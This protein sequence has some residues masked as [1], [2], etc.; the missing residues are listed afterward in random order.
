MGCALYGH[1]SGPVFA[2]CSSCRIN[3]NTK[4][5]IKTELGVLSNSWKMSNHLELYLTSHFYKMRTVKF[6][7]W[8]FLNFRWNLINTLLSSALKIKY[9]DLW[10]VFSFHHP[11]TQ[12]ASLF[13]TAHFHLSSTYF[14][15]LSF[16]NVLYLPESLTALKKKS[17]SFKTNKTT[18]MDRTKFST[19]KVVQA[20][21][22]GRNLEYLEEVR[23]IQTPH[24]RI[25]M[26]SVPLH[27]H[28]PVSNPKQRKHWDQIKPPSIFGE[29]IK[30]TSWTLIC[31]L[32]KLILYL[33][34]S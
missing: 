3:Y 30:S 10:G 7:G 2:A 29:V 27:R 22:C 21:D 18:N 14:F 1:V 28:T 20:L 12:T 32:I 34:L 6:C 25:E 5:I 33:N 17:R 15:F 31:N 19:D 24:R 11:Q 26:R 23:N 4:S 8:S 9:T 13:P 16:Q